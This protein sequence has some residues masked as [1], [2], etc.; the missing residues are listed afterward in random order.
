MVGQ[1]ATL[2]V[3]TQNALGFPVVPSQVTWLSDD[4]AIASVNSTGSVT[5]V[6]VGQTNI[7]ALA[8]GLSATV[9]TN[10]TAAGPL[11][12]PPPPPPPGPAEVIFASDWSTA[13]GNTEAAIEDERGEYGAWSGNQ[14]MVGFG[15]EVVTVA[16]LGL[17]SPGFSNCLKIPFG[18]A[19]RV[20][21]N[22]PDLAVGDSRNYRAYFAALYP[23]QSVGPGVG[24]TH[25]ADLFDTRG[26]GNAWFEPFR[27]FMFNEPTFNFGSA[28]ADENS[29]RV[30]ATGFPNV[31]KRRFWGMEYH[32]VRTSS[33]KMELR[34]A[35][36]Y[37][38]QGNQVKDKTTYTI[39]LGVTLDEQPWVIT[40]PGAGSLDNWRM[41]VNGFGGEGPDGNDYG[42]WAGVAI[43]DNVD[44]I[45]PWNGTY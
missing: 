10:V 40:I 38:D 4:D 41:G 3:T 45:G 31:A 22:V 9:P 12:P 1:T 2:S 7:Y 5:G 43:V 15:K 33:D 26:S 11:P 36:M 29:T 6:S 25:P 42:C 21:L 35:W 44:Q 27:V 18:D 13:L 20:T 34:E 39:A 16:S 24:N 14:N 28:Q 30:Q 32:F 19:G 17:T 23:T 37:D 8:S